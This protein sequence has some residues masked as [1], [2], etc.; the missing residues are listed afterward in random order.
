MPLSNSVLRRYTPPTCTLEIASR[1][2]PMSRWMGRSVVKQLRFDLRFDDPRLPEEQ[3]VSIHGDRDQ[4]ETLLEV[5]TA[6]VQDLLNS[7]PDRFNAIFSGGTTLSSDSVVPSTSQAVDLNVFDSPTLLKEPSSLDA[8][9]TRLD[10]QETPPADLTPTRRRIFLQPGKGLTH[11][12]FL[13][14]LAT[15]ETGPVVYL[16]VLQLFDLAT[17]L[18]EYAT[19][20]VAL[21]TAPTRSSEPAVPAWAGIAAMLVLG[22]G[23]TT[24]VQ[25][26]NRP[27]SRQQTATTTVIPGSSSNNSIALQPSP[28]PPLSSLQTLPPAPPP[29]STTIPVIPNSI[30]P[31]SVPGTNPAVPGEPRV[32]VPQSS[33]IKPL[34]RQTQQQIVINPSPRQNRVAIAGDAAKTSAARSRQ[35]TISISP[36]SSA[37]APTVILPSASPQIN[38]RNRDLEAALSLPNSGATPPRAGSNN[39]PALPNAA[40]SD[41]TRSPSTSTSSQPRRTASNTIPQVQQ[42]RAYFSRRWQPPASLKETLEYSLVLDVDGTIQRIEPLGQAARTYIDETGMPLI[43]ESFVSPS[44]NGQTP[45]IRVVL[46]PSGKVQTFL[47]EDTK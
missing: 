36:N 21:P 42:A 20:V 10:V 23:L 41:A 11:D 22:V 30:P 27:N 9:F 24:M 8:S 7:S 3:R 5:V 32:N 16:G 40:S 37:T 45:R 43:G 2:S 47:E 13:G 44:T 14:S 28:T 19:D 39:Y 35:P 38:P 18:D 33:P 29:G 25:V 17:A 4:L 26:L 46:A 34:P 12:L 31:I 6:Y 1:S 15:E